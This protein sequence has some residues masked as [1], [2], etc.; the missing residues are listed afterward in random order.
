MDCAQFVAAVYSE[1]GVTPEI[2]TPDYSPQY[3]LHTDEERLAEFVKRY[4][5]Q[6]D[7]AKADAGDLAL[8]HVGPLSYAHAAIIVIVAGSQERPH[9]PRP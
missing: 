8:Y 3:F 2:P 7:E 9:H 1:S 6:I 5:Q 4:G